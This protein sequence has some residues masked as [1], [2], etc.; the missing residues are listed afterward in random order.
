LLESSGNPDEAFE[1]LTAALRA[2]PDE[3][4]LLV[5]RGAILGRLKRYPEAETDLRR[6]I[7]LQPGHFTAHLTL[8]LVLWRKGLPGDAA[9]SLRRAIDLEPRDAE[10]HYYLGE[11]LNQAGDYAE[12]RTAL[13]QSPD[14][15]PIRQRPTA[16][17]AGCSIGWACRTRRRRCTAAPVRPVTSDPGR[18]C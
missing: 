7:K 1:Q 4:A 6:A 3:P 10:A 17:S 9:A 18:R 13:E 14:W 5:S 2:R 16:C 12:A 8:G 11:A 15:M